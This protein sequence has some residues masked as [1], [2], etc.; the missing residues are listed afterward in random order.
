MDIYLSFETA[1]HKSEGTV[2][3]GQGVTFLEQTFDPSSFSLF[4]FH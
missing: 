2:Q 4:D 3:D 1:V